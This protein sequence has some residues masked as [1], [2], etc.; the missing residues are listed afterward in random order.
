MGSRRLA[1]AA[2]R[3]TGER[4]SRH[5]AQR[6]GGGRREEVGQAGTRHLQDSG[7]VDSGSRQRSIGFVEPRG[8]LIR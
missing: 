7:E 2:D 5:D 8:C 4:W 6:R 3:R 1:Q